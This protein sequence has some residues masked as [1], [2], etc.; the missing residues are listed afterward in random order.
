MSFLDKFIRVLPLNKLVSLFPLEKFI[1]FKHTRWGHKLFRAPWTGRGD[2]RAVP[3]KIWIYWADGRDQAPPLVKLC[4]RSWEVM[5]PGWDVIVLDKEN[6]ADYA[7]LSDLEAADV[8]IQKRSNILRCRLLIVH[9]GVWADGTILC[10]SS[11]DGWLFAAMRSEAFMFSRP[12]VYRMTS[13]WFLAAEPGSRLLIAQDQAYTRYL[14][15]PPIY[16]QDPPPPYFSFHYTVE[17]LY[18]T[19]RVFRSDFDDMPKI[20]SKPLLSLQRDLQDADMDAV[21][22]YYEKG[23]AGLPMQKLNWRK[24]LDWGVLANVIA[25]IDPRLEQIIQNIDVP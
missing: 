9:G 18:R 5:N 21:G 12:E 11:L 24:P 1:R 15:D 17:Y 20:H 7:D 25:K 22:P 14:T 13:N 10:T 16:K 6:L 19:D 4:I 2:F 23:I 3:R 8:P